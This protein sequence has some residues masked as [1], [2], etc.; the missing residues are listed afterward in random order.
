LRFQKKSSTPSESIRKTE[1]Y[2]ELESFKK[3]FKRPNFYR[4]SLD[5]AIPCLF[6]YSSKVESRKD[7]L[8][9][10]FLNDDL[11]TV[12]QFISHSGKQII[13]EFRRREHLLELDVQL[14]EDMASSEDEYLVD[15]DE[16]MNEDEVDLE[17]N[18]AD[19]LNL[20]DED[21]KDL[22]HEMDEMREEE[23]E[24]K[25]KESSKAR[26]KY[27][28]SAVDDKFFSLAEMAAFLDEQDRME[29]TGPSVLDTVDDSETAPADYGYEDFF[30]RKDTIEERE[31]ANQKERKKKRNADEKGLRNKKKSVRFAMDVEEQ[32]EEGGNEELAEEEPTEIS[33]GPVLLGGEE[34]SEQPQSNL[35]K[36]LK[37]LKQTIAKLEQ[38]NLAPRSW[39]LSGEVTAQQRE[40]NELLETHVQFDHGAKK[41]PEI[42]EVF[43]EKL[44]DL[45][46]QR[47]KDKAFDDVVRKK[48]VEERTEPYKNQAIEE[49]EIVKTSLAE[50]YEKEY[51][52]A[53]GEAAA[54]NTVNE[55]HV[56]IEKRM[57]ELFRLIDA[58]SNFDYTPPEEIKEKTTRKKKKVKSEQV[59]EGGSKYML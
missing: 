25:A 37:R 55:E 54:S 5:R 24:E 35:K 42:T 14:K 56:A 22:E 41:A 51:Q 17:E 6:A 10:E 40:E 16:E 38:E 50:V 7:D 53:A 18:E 13:K 28:K 21:L 33:Q 20:N 58:L 15:E 45:I 12:W 46:K 32:Q 30:G 34:E 47:I 29:G 43:T 19:L 9:S 2:V 44:E 4:R 8:P 49:Q 52:K 36:S 3:L 23:E 39:Q 57:R 27:P 11:E 26:K 48:R 31:S 1:R 59:S